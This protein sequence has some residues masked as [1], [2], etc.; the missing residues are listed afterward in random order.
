MTTNY[1]H[2]ALDVHINKLLYTF[3][4]KMATLELTIERLWKINKL[5]VKNDFR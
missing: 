4:F 5:H 1:T 3:T 2:P